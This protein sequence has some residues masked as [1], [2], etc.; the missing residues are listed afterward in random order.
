MG[1]HLFLIYGL[2]ELHVAP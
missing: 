2:Y 1:E